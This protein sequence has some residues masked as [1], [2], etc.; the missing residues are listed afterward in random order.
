MYERFY[1]NIS[2]F[3]FVNDEP[4]PSDVIFVPGNGYPHMAERA[5]KLWKEGYGRWVLPSGRYAKALGHFVGV[6]DKKEKYYGDYQTEWEFLADV[7][8][9]NGVPE[10][11][12]LKEN[13]AT[14]TYEN[15]INSR[16]A[17]IERN[18]SLHRGIICCN[19]VHARRCKMYYELVF[20]R[21]EFLVC[22]A[23]AEGITK[24]NWH[25][26][27]RGIAAVLGEMDRCGRQFEQILEEMQGN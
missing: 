25:K 9:K 1:Q 15:A 2:D 4:L 21:A 8:V 11:K 23:E 22:P 6:Q 20:P 14:F 17:L 19:S 10:E 7:L 12:I 27:G 26:T 16:S 13:R 24:E 18:I 5:A 3:I